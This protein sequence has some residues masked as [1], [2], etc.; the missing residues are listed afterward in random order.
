[1]QLAWQN[2]VIKLGLFKTNFRP[3]FKAISK[4]RSSL[5]MLSSS[6]YCGFRPSNPVI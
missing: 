6:R 5:E 3:R 2:R 1:M 4:K